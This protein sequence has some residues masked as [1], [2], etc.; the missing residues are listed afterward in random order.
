MTPEKIEKLFW[1]ALFAWFLLRSLLLGCQYIG[2]A[3]PAATGELLKFFTQADIDAGRAYALKGFWF[4]AIYGVVFVAILVFLVRSGLANMLWQR[5][6]AFFGPG[7][8]R[9]D[10][11]FIVVFL[12]IVQGLSFPSDL[13]FGHW[14]ETESGF[15]T[16]GFGGWFV[17]YLKSLLIGVAFETAGLLL[18]LTV[19]RWLPE[20]WP[21]LLPL[22][23]GGFALAI[24]LLAP[25]IITP[26]FY[27]Q[28]PLEPG[29]F[30]D[31]LLEMAAR[32]GMAVNEIY[33]IDESRYSKHTNA[34]FTG[35]GRFRRIVLYDNLIK[36]HTPDEAAL[37]FAH[38][39]GH[40]QYNHVVWGLSLGVLGM[41]LAGLLYQRLFP[42]LAAVG[43]LGLGEISAA[44]NLPFLL[45]MATILQL[46][47]V[48]F[49]SQISQIMER[50]ADRVA[51]ELTGLRKVYQDAQVRLARDNRSDLLPHPLRVFWLYSHPPAIERIKAAA[52]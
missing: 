33:V 39:A 23:M 45:L 27:E 30:R 51:L 31:R 48:P 41:L 38:E 20:R 32:A 46:F 35:V 16:V 5:V 49:E 28:K 34:Y 2:N 19:L 21:L 22:A 25:M 36:S 44:Q 1:L 8:L 18:L 43:W 47:T 26:L 6:S 4:R 24:T 12:L 11:A 40:W 29:P 10:L 15:A 17:K 9:A 50:Q 14:R 7:I 52:Q 3:D 42:G 37:I 13:Y